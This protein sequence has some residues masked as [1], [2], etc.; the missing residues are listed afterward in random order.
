MAMLKVVDKAAC[1]KGLEQIR[2]TYGNWDRYLAQFIGAYEEAL[3]SY[4]RCNV[5]LSMDD[6]FGPE[7]MRERAEKNFSKCILENISGTKSDGVARVIA[8]ACEARTG[9]VRNNKAAVINKKLADCV[10]DQVKH[11]TSDGAASLILQSCKT[12]HGS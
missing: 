4:P 7:A 1:N 6:L 9:R 8:F 11:V 3:A 10:L 5:G 12:L 2:K